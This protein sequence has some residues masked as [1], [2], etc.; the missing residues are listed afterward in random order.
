MTDFVQN[1]LEQNRFDPAYIPT[2]ADKLYFS[3][4]HALR[5]LT[6]YIVLLALSTVISTYGVTSASTATVIGAMLVAPLMTPI[7]GATLALVTAREVRFLKSLLLVALSVAGVIALAA[8]MGL[9]LHFIDFADNPEITS[10]VNPGLSAMV[11]ALAAGAAGAFATSRS[12]VGDSLPG[13]AIAISLVPPLSVVGLALAHGRFEDAFGAFLLFLTNFLAI[14]LAGSVVFW[15]SGANLMKLTKEQAEVRKRAYIVTIISAIFVVLLLGITTYQAVRET[16]RN[17]AAQT[18]VDNWVEGTDYDPISVV[19]RF[20]QVN[21][22]V[23]GNG[24]LPPIEVLSQNLSQDLDADIFVL[25]KK[26]QQE[27]DFHPEETLP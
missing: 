1:W 27:K 18:A 20:P 15:V 10:R 16:M 21:V 2:L 7:M 17:N 14:I 5:K 25:V 19:M 22:T 4:D 11:V 23:A 24:D 8:L 6:N 9:P 12:E 3:G 13:V 26:I